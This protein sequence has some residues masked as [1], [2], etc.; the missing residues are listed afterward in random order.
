VTTIG[1]L[2]PLLL[3]KSF[4]AQFL[5]PMATAMAFGLMMTTALVLI[6]VP[7]MYSFFGTSAREG[8]VEEAELQ[9]GGFGSAADEEAADAEWLPADLQQHDPRPQSVSA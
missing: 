8:H 7:V 9:P 4:Q 1:G 5:V 2:L 3:E 6:L